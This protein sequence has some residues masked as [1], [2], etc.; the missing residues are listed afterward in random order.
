MSDKII[1][2]PLEIAEVVARLILE[3]SY[4][5]NR[6]VEGLHNYGVHDILLFGS[7]LRG[8]AHDVDMLLIHNLPELHDF[9]IVT[10]YDPKS[11]YWYPNPDAKREDVRWTSENILEA[12]GSPEVQ[13]PIEKRFLIGDAVCDIYYPKSKFIPMGR[14]GDGVSVGE[15]ITI[16]PQ[17]G[18][19]DFEVIGECYVDIEDHEGTEQRVNALFEEKITKR[20]AVNQIRN[21]LAARGLEINGTLDMHVMER[22]LLCSDKADD[23]RA[24][25]I[26][27]CRD[28]TFW[29]SVLTSGRLY[30]KETGKFDQ[31]VEQKYPGAYRFFR[32]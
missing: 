30:N 20:Q 18:T 26:R 11:G 19:V 13:N 10:E 6:N 12:L 2:N 31:T 8:D 15:E 29:Y 5:N 23:D 24:M 9:G 16:Y 1:Q 3:Y 17:S 28:P 27:Q 25:V 7:T 22:Y 32:Q 21:A 14:R 4:R